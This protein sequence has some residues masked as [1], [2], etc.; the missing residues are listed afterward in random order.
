MEMKR[1]IGIIIIL[2]GL[3][4]AGPLYARVNAG[5]RAEEKRDCIEMQSLRLEGYEVVPPKWCYEQGFLD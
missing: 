1:N 4:A 5:L 3:W 2:G